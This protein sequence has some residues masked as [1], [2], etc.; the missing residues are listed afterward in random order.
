MRIEQPFMRKSGSFLTQEFQTYIR[1]YMSAQ[2]WNELFCIVFPRKSNISSAEE[3]IPSKK[4][5]RKRKFPQSK[6]LFRP[7]Y[8]IRNSI[9]NGREISVPSGKRN[10][11]EK[12]PRNSI[13]KFHTEFREKIPQ[14]SVLKN[15]TEFHEKNSG[16]FRI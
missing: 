14:N 15:Q 12:I 1:S 7:E 4:N 13:F 11:A 3:K 16:E 8:G 6:F 9:K 10:F 5:W 2:R